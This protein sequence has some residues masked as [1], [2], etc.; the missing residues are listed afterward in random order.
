MKKNKEIKKVGSPPIQRPLLVYDGDCSFC[1][2]WV[3][4][5]KLKTGPL[6]D[7][8]PYQTAARRFLDVPQ[9]EFVKAVQF[10]ETN[11]HISSAAEAVFRLLAFTPGVGGDWLF[12]CYQ[13]LPGFASLTERIYALTAK[14]RKAVSAC[15]R[16][17]SGKNSEPQSFFVA[18]WLF[19]RGL[20]IIYLIAFGSLWTQ[21][22]PLIGSN[23]IFPFHLF[24]EAARSQAGPK[25]YWLFPTLAWL[26]PADSVLGLLCGGGTALSIA[27]ILGVA[28]RQI[29]FCLWTLYLSLISISGDFLLFQWDNLLLEVGFLSIFFAPSTL[30]WRTSQEER[31]SRLSLGLIW[32]LLFRLMFSS[33]VVKLASHDPTWRNFT[34]LA[35]HYQTQ[36]LPNAWSW[37]AHQLPITAQKFSAL[38]M[39][40]IELAAPFLIFMPRPRW[41]RLLGSAALSFLQI[42]ILLTG[43]YCFFNWLTLLL[44]LTLAEDRLWPVKLRLLF[45]EK[46]QTSKPKGNW[47]D[48]G[49][50]PLGCVILSIN[51]IQFCV[52]FKWRAI[53][54]ESAYKWYG[55][56][57]PFRTINNYG[58]FAV[59]TTRRME[60]V[61]TGSN[62]GVEWK[63]YEFKYKP[64]NLKSRPAFTA[65]H[66]PRLD[67]QMWFAALSDY[68]SQQWFYNL[69]VRILQN[70]KEVLA[71][72][73]KNPFPK[74]PPKHLRALYY[75]YK[76]TDSNTRKN[77]GQWWTR[78]LKGIYMPVL[79]RR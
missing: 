66:Q 46:P 50:V 7:Y 17:L 6:V 9:K 37:Y 79:T 58:L 4:S 2:G 62:D 14:H 22:Y 42:L 16:V 15:R 73:A 56:F 3:Q 60:V 30:L 77:T 54:P 44:I 1:K 45:K 51:L 43:N 53:L 71:L 36:P 67:W 49:I 27:L 68:R 21:I 26:N 72:L 55:L 12:W 74:G 24:L 11:G 19:F 28:P 63:E 61:L 39:F 48:R 23:G 5:W 38:I 10:I 8:E 70:K 20:G 32:W 76:F 25:A 64:G 34:A 57:S 33:G 47:L 35:Y 69:C 75:E 65:P 13:N 29:C 52:M 41:A 31:V 78:E 18:R 59:M 40:L